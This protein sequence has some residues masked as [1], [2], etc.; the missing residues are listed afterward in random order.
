MVLSPEDSAYTLLQITDRNISD[1]DLVASFY[2][3]YT[4]P[5]KEL[6]RRYTSTYI[7][8]LKI[9]ATVRQSRLLLFI[10]IIIPN[11]KEHN[12]G[13]LTTARLP[14]IPTDWA[15][16]FWDEGTGS[17]ANKNIVDLTE[18]SSTDPGTIDDSSDS[19]GEHPSER[20]RH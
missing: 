13:I 15:E 3:F 16:R 10:L 9:I 8:A 18:P 2:R 20:S 6:P 14:S 12:V 4:N 7:G 5:P 19:D 1:N 11:L 17:S